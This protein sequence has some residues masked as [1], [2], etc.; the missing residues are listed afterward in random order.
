MISICTI[1]DGAS[2][3]EVE[4]AGALA[5]VFPAVA[6]IIGA[7]HAMSATKSS[8]LQA[9]IACTAHSSGSVSSRSRH[10]L[11]EARRVPLAR[12]KTP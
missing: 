6:S 8:L 9:L 3:A 5:C 2:V 11:P 12:L 7:L 10:S 4:G 1:G